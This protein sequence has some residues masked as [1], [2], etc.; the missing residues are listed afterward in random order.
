MLNILLKDA[1]LQFGEWG[2]W[3]NCSQSCGQKGTRFRTRKCIILPRKKSKGAIGGH[4]YQ[5][6]MA[7]PKSAPVQ[8]KISK[9][10]HRKQTSPTSSGSSVRKQKASQ[11]NVNNSA[12][13]DKHSG[14]IPYEKYLKTKYEAKKMEKQQDTLRKTL[15]KILPKPKRGTRAVASPHLKS[16]HHWNPFWNQHNNRQN[17]IRPH[18]PNLP[19][20]T[21]V[22]KVC[23]A[24]GTHMRSRCNVKNCPGKTSLS[25]QDLKFFVLSNFAILNEM[26]QFK[27][28]EIF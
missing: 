23:S 8:K 21:R 12:K 11:K 19:K 6:K 16:R 27:N 4:P 2:Y 13:L 7:A 17:R 14:E 18:N 1:Y 28:F 22:L 9:E 5:T 20:G 15:R 26:G 24:H 25:V 3:S 10:Q